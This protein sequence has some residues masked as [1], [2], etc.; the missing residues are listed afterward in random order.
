M[1]KFRWKLLILLRA[2][3][4]LPIV[5]LRAFGIHNVHLMADT[6]TARIKKSKMDDA[7]DHLRQLIDL[8]VRSIAKSREQVENIT[9]HACPLVIPDAPAEQTARDFER[10]KRIIP[11]FQALMRYLAGG[12]ML[13]PKNS[14]VNSSRRTT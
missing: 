1:M 2:L 13:P 12:G 8:Y 3:S 11:V 7:H 9:A 4:T 14:A 6:L 10:L 5:G